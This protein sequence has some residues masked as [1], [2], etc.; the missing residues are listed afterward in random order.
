MLAPNF[1][2][3]KGNYRDDAHSC[4]MYFPNTCA[5][6]MSEALVRT[7]ESFLAVFKASGRNL[8]PHGY[9]RGAQDL[10]SALEKSSGLGRHRAGWSNPGSAPKDI[11][12]RRGVICYMR[13]PGFAGQGHIDLWDGNGPVGQ[14]YWDSQT[15]WLWSLT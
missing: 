2:T 8:C 10:A 5:I 1:T 7:D 15:I 14:D 6:R 13:I 4:S 11:M 12:G 3:L 9:M